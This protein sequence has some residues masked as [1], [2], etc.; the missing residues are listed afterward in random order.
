M[1]NQHEALVGLAKEGSRKA[2]APY[3]KF[4]VGCVIISK[5]GSSFTGCNIENI[6]F[7]L[8]ICAE[9]AAI[10]KAISTE[11]PEFKIETVIIYTP[12]DVPITPCGACRQVLREFGDDFYI[13]S[14]C[15]GEKSIKEHISVLLPSSPDIQLLPNRHPTKNRILP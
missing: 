5:K 2:Y 14:I 13:T 3:S 8:T 11:G 1:K 9:R 6:S 7:G 4:P 12:T 15:D 10:S